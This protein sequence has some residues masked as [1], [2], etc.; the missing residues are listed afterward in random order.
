MTKDIDLEL[1]KIL[2]KIM[3]NSYR[4]KEIE[5]IIYRIMEKFKKLV[6]SNKNEEKVKNLR[7]KFE[8][9]QR[10]FEAVSKNNSRY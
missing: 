2:A 7:L 9:I 3:E 6:F 4:K 8:E 5:E 1:S 10:N